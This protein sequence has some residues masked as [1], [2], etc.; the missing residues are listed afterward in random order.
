MRIPTRREKSSMRTKSSANTIGKISLF[1]VPLLLA[2]AST[3]GAEEAVA[4]AAAEAPA[5]TAD[6]A[7]KIE[8][9][10]VGVDTVWVLITAALVFFMNAGFGL[11]ESG[12]CRAKNAVNILSK[13]FIVFAASSISFYLI[14]WG[15]MF[16]SGSPYAGSDGLFMLAGA[17]NSP[18]MGDAYQG[19]YSSIA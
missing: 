19:A 4:E 13:N 2:A 14:G 7:T 11:V 5:F 6:I 9:L 18:A 15:L 12:L 1:A 10:V 3:V 17:D 8:T 16:G